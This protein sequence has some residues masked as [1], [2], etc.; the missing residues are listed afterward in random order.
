MAGER[1]APGLG[2]YTGWTLGSSGYKAQLDENFV[3]LSALVAG[4]V[5]SLVATEPATPANG[6]RHL[7]TGGANAD[8]L[9]IRDDGAWFYLP[10]FEGMRLYDESTGLALI[11]DGTAWVG[12]RPY[13]IRGGFTST[14]SASQILG[15]H[16][17]VRDIFFPANFFGSVGF[18]GTNP[19]SI[20]NIDV[21]DD[22]VSIGTVTIST[23]GVVT[24]STVS[25][26]AVLV[27]KGSL[28][29]FVGAASA[30][31]SVQNAEWTLLGH[32]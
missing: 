26:L 24:F 22:G 4:T 11:Y 31:A 6:D 21:R 25:G 30:V 18:V 2:L 28:L 16:A 3:R 27:A 19:G 15:R 14:P 20:M 13:D 12:A 17:V 5:M 10:P 32:A 1:Q 8:S 9:A 7:M 29:T 23:G